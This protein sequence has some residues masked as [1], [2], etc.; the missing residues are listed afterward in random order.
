M[1]EGLGIDECAIARKEPGVLRDLTLVCA[2]CSTKFRC[3]REIEAGTAALHY[4]DYCANS[5]TIDALRKESS[6]AEVAEFIR[7]PACC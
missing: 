6:R 5:Y 7:G 3:N 4:Q 2:L 1:L